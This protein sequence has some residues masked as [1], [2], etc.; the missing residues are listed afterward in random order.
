[1]VSAAE[2]LLDGRLTIC[3][4]P[5]MSCMLLSSG[6]AMVKDLRFNRR[7]SREKKSRDGQNNRGAVVKKQRG[8]GALFK[9]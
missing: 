3:Q 9:L 7:E 6:A 5:V 1:M 4:S 2:I 8:R